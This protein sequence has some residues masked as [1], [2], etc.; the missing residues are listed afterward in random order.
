M[1]TII[2]ILQLLFLLFF[3]TATVVQTP[4]EPVIVTIPAPTEVP[5]DGGSQ[6]AE[7][8]I[9]T[10]AVVES[11]DVLLLES[12]PVQIQLQV[13]GYHPD[14][15]QA[16]VEVVQQRDGNTV[17]VQVYRILPAAV[18]CPMVLQP[19]EET[20]RLDGGFEPGTYQIDVNGVVTEVTL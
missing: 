19:L 7:P 6:A 14:G 16:P 4:V 18:M 10:L 13:S 5:V 8:T 9:R 17:T 11:V 3:G 12:L 15:C 2:I 1:E 20:I